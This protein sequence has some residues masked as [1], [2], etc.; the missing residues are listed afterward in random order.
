M[1]TRLRSRLEAAESKAGMRGS[2]DAIRLFY[3]SGGNGRGDGGHD[4]SLSDFL[5]SKGHDMSYGQ[6]RI[7]HFCPP[8]D[9]DAKTF[10]PEPLADLTAKIGRAA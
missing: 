5:T 8:W 4:G 2:D 1:T 7:V 9:G 10:T 6:P 3:V